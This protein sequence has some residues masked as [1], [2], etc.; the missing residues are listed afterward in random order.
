MTRIHLNKNR[1]EYYFSM[2][3]RSHTGEFVDNGAKNYVYRAYSYIKDSSGAVQLF[4]KPLYFT[5]YDM[6]SIENAQAGL[7]YDGYITS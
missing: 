2:A 6:A 7:M 3:V 1:I 5:I 4:S